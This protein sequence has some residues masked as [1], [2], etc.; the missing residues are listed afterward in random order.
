MIAPSLPRKICLTLALL[1]CCAASAHAD[2]PTRAPEL[3]LARFKG[4]L[5]SATD[6]LFGDD[7]HGFQVRSAVTKTTPCLPSS[8]A[9]RV[10]LSHDAIPPAHDGSLRDTAA[11][12]GRARATGGW[13]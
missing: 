5:R 8:P 4:A 13:G 2:A 11:R 10:V 9:T 1:G 12:F 7:E 6:E 3:S